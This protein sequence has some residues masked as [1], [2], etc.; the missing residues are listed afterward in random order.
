MLS[1]KSYIQHLMERRFY[2][3]NYNISKLE[4]GILYIQYMD[5]QEN[6]AEKLKEELEGTIDDDTKGIILD[7]RNN[8]GGTLN[9][10]VGLSDIFL[11][12]GVI[13][14]VRGRSNN[15]ESFEEFRATPGGFTRV[16]MIVLINGFS[17]SAAELAA[18]ALK[19]LERATIIGERSFGKGTV[20]ILNDLAD[21]SGIKYTTARY[22]LPSGITIDGIG[23]SPD[24]TVILTPE[25]TEDLQLERAIEEL[26][27]LIESN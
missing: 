1:R 5:F 10:A 15:Q 26:K 6:G 12:D 27:K 23:I 17:A 11:D 25:D 22:Y 2:V 8:L 3:P 14:T 9:D 21:G 13:V 20:Q 16:P 19:D 18:G 24:I 4:D 7:L